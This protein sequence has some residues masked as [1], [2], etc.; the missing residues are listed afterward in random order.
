[1]Q[2]QTALE[3]WEDEM[4]RVMEV[5]KQPGLARCYEVRAT[6]MAKCHRACE[7]PGGGS[8]MTCIRKAIEAGDLLAS[9]A[10]FKN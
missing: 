2:L 10:C 5:K 9:E 4:Q 3:P 7:A 8:T 1:M 6:R